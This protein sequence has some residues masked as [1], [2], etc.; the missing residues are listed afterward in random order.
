MSGTKTLD[1]DIYLYTMY[2]FCECKNV[3]MAWQQSM[4]TV[5]MVTT[6]C[7]IQH[8]NGN[9][10]KKKQKKQVIHTQKIFYKLHNNFSMTGKAI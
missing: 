7:I 9:E 6:R 10:V 4:T 5:V 8:Y 3:N 2:N 1:I